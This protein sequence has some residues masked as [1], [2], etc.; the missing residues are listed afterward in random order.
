M[1]ILAISPEKLAAVAFCSDTSLFET[2]DQLAKNTLDENKMPPLSPALVVSKFG[3]ILKA[4]SNVSMLGYEMQERFE[5]GDE[6]CLDKLNEIK[7]ATMQVVEQIQ[8][9]ESTVCNLTNPDL[10]KTKFKFRYT[11]PKDGDIIP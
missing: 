4:C 6:S 9:F 8:E 7:K 11:A 10:K 5:A 2:I 1:A 3:P